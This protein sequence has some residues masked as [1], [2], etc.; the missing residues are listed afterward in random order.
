MAGATLE[1]EVAEGEELGF[2]LG[3]AA[4]G[5]E[6]GYDD[7]IIGEVVVTV[8]MFPYFELD[9][10]VAS[11]VAEGCTDA[12]PVADCIIVVG[13]VALGNVD[14]EVVKQVFDTVSDDCREDFVCVGCCHF[15][16][17]WDCVLSSLIF[18]SRRCFWS[19]ARAV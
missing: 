9:V 7:D 3:V 14:A 12:V 18:S 5:H 2:V 10:D 17:F 13:S 15:F 1:D 19:R 8:G 6:V 4:T 11:E 16:E